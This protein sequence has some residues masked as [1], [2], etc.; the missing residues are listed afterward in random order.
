MLR[1]DSRLRAERTRFGLVKRKITVN[2][3]DGDAVD[4]TCFGLGDVAI[5]NIVEDALGVALDR[6]AQAATARSFQ[7]EGFARMKHV[8]G[9]ARGNYP[10]VRTAGVQNAVA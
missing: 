3:V 2:A 4:F 5:T 7:A 8:V 10:F 9:I 1:P 6:L